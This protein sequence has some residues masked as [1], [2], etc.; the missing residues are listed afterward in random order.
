MIAQDKDS[1]DAFAV[2]GP[3]PLQNVGGTGSAIDEISNENQ[4]RSLS[5]AVLKLRVNFGEEILKEVKSTM[6]VPDDIGPTVRITG[7]I[8]ALAAQES[9]HLAPDWVASS[10]AS[11]AGKP[12]TTSSPDRT[13]TFPVGLS[14]QD[15]GFALVRSLFRR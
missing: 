4:Q 12:T 5:R 14:L 3:K 8:A 13:L 2:V 6:D 1:L 10:W 11:P 7:R 9:Q 15:A